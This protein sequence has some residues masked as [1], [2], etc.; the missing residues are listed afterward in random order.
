MRSGSMPKGDVQA[1]FRLRGV[2]AK[3]GVGPLSGAAA[4]FHHASF[5]PCR[6]WVRCERSRDRRGMSYEQH[7]DCSRG[8]RRVACR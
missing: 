7:W 6:W 3:A 1:R 2:L 8:W 5:V 4:R